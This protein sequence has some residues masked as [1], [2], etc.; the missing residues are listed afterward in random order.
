MHKNIDIDILQSY[1]P[2]VGNII[3]NG[4]HIQMPYLS[5]FFSFKL[6]MDTENTILNNWTSLLLSMHWTD[7]G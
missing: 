5:Y 2:H 6:K 1:A 4:I 3:N 7:K